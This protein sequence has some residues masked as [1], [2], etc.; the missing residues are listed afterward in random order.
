MLNDFRSIK[1]E[2]ISR[3][4]RYVKRVGAGSISSSS[5]SVL[6]GNRKSKVNLVVPQFI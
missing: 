1:Q 6:V 3:Q 4:N 2:K 5:R